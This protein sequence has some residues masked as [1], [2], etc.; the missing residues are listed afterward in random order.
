MIFIAV[1]FPVRSEY[2]EEW[3]NLVD[4]FARATRREPGNLFFTW[5]RS[6]EEPNQFI[7][8]E[9]FSSP[10]SGEEHVNSEHFKEAMRWM[11]SVIADTPQIIHVNTPGSGWSEME[12]LTPSA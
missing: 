1:K 8:L 12:E 5:S 11:S 10:G 7:L 3:M 4:E 2:I 6:V 9:A